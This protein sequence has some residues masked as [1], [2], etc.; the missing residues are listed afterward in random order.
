MTMNDYMYRQFRPD[1][2]NPTLDDVLEGFRAWHA[3]PVPL[4]ESIDIS[5][6]V[7]WLAS[8]EARYVTGVALP[9]DAA[10]TNRF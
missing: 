5:N 8:D 3:L 9:I 6:A 2:A 7:A 1:L 4:I 10:M